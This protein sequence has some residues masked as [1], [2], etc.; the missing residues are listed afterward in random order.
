MTQ[1]LPYDPLLGI[2]QKKIEN[3]YPNENL[4]KNVHSSTIDSSLKW[5]QP[6]N[7]LTKSCTCCNTNE[8]TYAN[9]NNTHKKCNIYM[10]CPECTNSQKQE[11]DCYFPGSG[12]KGKWGLI[13]QEVWDFFLGWQKCSGIDGGDYCWAR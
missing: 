12:E 9:W 1:Q 8:P 7:W 10:T 4:Y 11:A 6:N 2:Y 3:R 13:A 5:K